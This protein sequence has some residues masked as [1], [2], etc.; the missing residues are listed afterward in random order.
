MITT[1]ASV[2]LPAPSAE[3]DHQQMRMLVETLEAQLERLRKQLNAV[4]DLSSTPCSPGIPN[5]VFAEGLWGYFP[6]VASNPLDGLFT[7]SAAP[8]SATWIRVWRYD[9]RGYDLWPLLATKTS[10]H[11]AYV[12]SRIDSTNYVSY[13]LTGAPTLTGSYVNIPVAYAS[14]SGATLS[15]SKW[16]DCFI[17]INS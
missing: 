8:A 10:A 12:Q 17:H 6:T 14:P 1:I 2:G 11:K 13:T 5:G 9:R 15:E 16:R 7:L 4:I 3:Y